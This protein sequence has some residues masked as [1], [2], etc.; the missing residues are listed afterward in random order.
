MKFSGCV[1]LLFFALSFSDG[2]AAMCRISDLQKCLDSVCAQN[3][4]PSERCYA[5]GTS[6]AVRPTSSAPVMQSLA[7]GTS[8]KN[9]LS[10]SELKN[11]PVD[12]GERYQWATSECLKKLKDCTAENV[13]NNYDKLIEQSCKVALGDAEYAASMKKSSVKK[14]SNQCNSEISRCL[15]GS[16]RCDS[17][18]L[19][20][21]VDAEFDRNFS[22]CMA[23][24]SGCDEFLQ[25]LRSTMLNSRN[26][27]IS[28]KD[29]RIT[30]LIKLKQLEREEKMASARRLCTSGG[31]A[32]CILE[33][34]GNMPIGLDE[35]GKCSN[36]NERQWATS[37]CKFVDI[38][39]DRLK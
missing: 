25:D 23:E 10:A 3:A 6:A 37:L 8:S 32:D 5:C 27:M 26:R 39:C 19:K 35:D 31:K 20:C 29:S 2:W 13:T 34:C 24:V 28:E 14:T 33:I 4:D 11:A 22:A 17:N 15:L 1:F 7:L 21:Q 16:A 30:D 12:P 9:T 18:M 38:A 36:Q